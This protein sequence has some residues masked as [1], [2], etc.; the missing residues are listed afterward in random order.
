M[1]AVAD[2]DP[3]AVAGGRRD[4]LQAVIRDVGIVRLR[5]IRCRFDSQQVVAVGDPA[6]RERPRGDAVGTDARPEDDETADVHT[7]WRRRRGQIA[8]D[9]ASSAVGSGLPSH[10][11]APKR[12]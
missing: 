7:R 11:R 5:G 1:G 12:F 9:T 4:D 10:S 6:V 2:D 8:A 3:L